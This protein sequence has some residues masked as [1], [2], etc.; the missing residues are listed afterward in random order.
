V[1][2]LL[3]THAFLWFAAGDRRLSRRA[4]TAMEAG[5][6]E[7]RISAACGGLMPMVAA[8]LQAWSGG[9]LTYVLAYFVLICGMAVG[10]VISSHETARSRRET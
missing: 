1:T 6:A 5:D 8:S 10:A 9:S 2:L 3:D 7:L 4:R